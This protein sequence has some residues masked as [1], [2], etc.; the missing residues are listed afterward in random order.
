MTLT[1]ENIGQAFCKLDLPDQEQE[2]P[3]SIGRDNKRWQL[4]Q[5]SSCDMDSMR[6]G[7]QLC[8]TRVCL[9]NHGTLRRHPV[10]GIPLEAE[11]RHKD[12]Q[13]LMS[14]VHGL[15][16]NVIMLPSL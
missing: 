6:R 4:T 1:L 5:V 9:G 2:V 16:V 8:V 13:A 15:S 11:A 3:Y 10:P 14:S 12:E 7:D